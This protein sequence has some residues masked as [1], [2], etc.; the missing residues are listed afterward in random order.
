MRHLKNFVDS[1]FYSF[2]F[3]SSVIGHIF[4]YVCEM[5]LRLC[6]KIFQSK[7]NFSVLISQQIANGSQIALYNNKKMTQQRLSLLSSCLS[8]QISSGIISY[9]STCV[10]LYF[11]EKK[12][13]GYQKN[14]TNLSLRSEKKVTKHV[15]FCFRCILV[16]RFSTE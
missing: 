10:N 1:K 8:F 3:L 6:G 2:S 14:F 13:F 15:E 16:F 5:Q 7:F 12:L 11:Q 9:L 4:A